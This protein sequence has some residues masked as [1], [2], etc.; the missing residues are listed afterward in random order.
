MLS[1][2]RF[3]LTTSHS[4]RCSLKSRCLLRICPRAHRRSSSGARSWGREMLRESCCRGHATPCV[5]TVPGSATRPGQHEGQK[6]QNREAAS[7][8]DGHPPPRA[9]RSPSE[10]GAAHLTVPPARPP[11]AGRADFPTGPMRGS[12]RIG[13]LEQQAGTVAAG[14]Q[15]KPSSA[16][17]IPPTYPASFSVDPPAEGLCLLSQAL[18]ACPPTARARLEHSS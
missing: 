15:Q 17:P 3:S 6:A 7:S 1:V 9:S 16:A 13:G 5:L 8:S 14:D 4:P 10:V 11:A 12:A 2:Q 18:P